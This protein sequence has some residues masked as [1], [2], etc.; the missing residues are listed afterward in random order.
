MAIKKVF[1]RKVLSIFTG[2]SLVL[3]SLSPVTLIPVLAS[4]AYA[5]ESQDIVVP[6]SDPTPEVTPDEIQPTD[7]QEATP[8]PEET[9]E[10]TP[11]L[12]AE[13]TPTDTQ[14]PT[15]EP[16]PAITDEAT[17]T[18]EPT[19]EVTETGAEPT[20]SPVT[21]DGSPPQET[22][23]PEQQGEILDG[24]STVAPTP[25][26][27]EAAVPDEPEE[28]GS[29]SA[30]ILKNIEAESLPIETLDLDAQDPLG[31][32]SLVTDK[33]DYAPTDT[34][35]IA[36]SGFIP[37]ETY[38]LI[39]SS[40]D[41]P[42]VS[43]EDT[44]TAGADGTFVYAYQLDGNYRPNYKVEAFNGDDVLIATTTF[45]D[46]ESSAATVPFSDSFGTSNTS[47]MTNWDEQ[48][49]AEILGSTSGEDTTRDGTSSNK[50]AKIGQGGWIRRT[51]N[52]IGFQSLQLKYY[53]K[54]DSDAE[55][56]DRGR[57]EYCSGATCTSFTEL[58]NHQ[59][60]NTS[61]SSLQ[62]INLPASLN[63]STFRIRFRDDSN[64]SDEYFRVDQ[65]EVS[66]STLAQPDLV[67]A[68]TNSV[69]GN[70]VIN[71]PFTWTLTV[72]NI[73]NASATFSDEDIL[74]DNLPSSGANYSPTSNIPVIT[75]GGITGSID[76]DIVNNDDL[77]C[78]DNSGGSSVV[79]PAGGSF[80][81]SITVTPTA[82]GTLINPRSGGSNK[83]QV[84]PDT[85]ETESNESN[86]SCSNS[87][88]VSY[89]V[90]TNPSLPDSCGLDV[91]LILDSS[92]SMSNGDIT[93]VKNAATTL[94][95]ALM[96]S[97]PTRIGVID[98]DT[99]VISSLSPTTNKTNVLNAVN[100]IGHTGATEYT[101]W[102]SAL[103]AA[104]AMI[105]S[106][107]L[108]VI[109][110]DG[111]PT[112]SDGPLSDLD[113]AINAANAIKT[114]GTR[115]LAI[116]INS[117]G[118]SGGLDLP[119]L[120]AITG[121]QD[122]TVPPGTITD[123]NT[124]DVVLGDISQLG[125]A[126]ADLASAL[127]GGTITVTKLVDADGNLQTTDDQSPAAGWEFN[128]GG[129]NKTTGDDGLTDSVTLDDG[130][131]SVIET[132]QEGYTLLGASCTGAV[133]NGSRD[134]NG[135]YGIAIDNSSIVSCIFVNSQVGYIVVDKVT[136]PSG[137]PQSFTFD[138][139]WGNDFN[140][141]DQDNPLDS[142]PIPA[143]TY[144]VS[145][146]VPTG[147]DP[148]SATC[149]DQSN[150]SSISLQAGETVTCTFTNTKRSSISGYKYEDADGDIQTAGDRS[151]IAD[152]TIELWQWATDTWSY[153]TGTLTDSLGFFSFQNLI[154]GSY[155][156]REVVPTGWTAVSPTGI[157]VS[158]APGDESQNNDFVNFENVTVTAC[159]Q[160]DPDGN[161]ETPEGRSDLENWTVHLIKDG[162]EVDT[163]TTGPDG[164]FT[165]TDFGPGAY[166][167]SEDVQT[168]WGNLT[169]TTND[170]G[171]VTSGSQS[172]F[173][174]VNVELGTI[175]VQKVTDP[176]GQSDLFTFSGDTGGTA[177]D[178]G[179]ITVNDLLPGQYTS[180]ENDPTPDYDLTGI[181]CDDGNSTVDIE[182]RTA[183]I[184]VEPGEEV[185]CT[186]TNT[187]RGSVTVTKFHDRNAD[188][189][190]DEEEQELSE[191]DITLGDET[192]AT[193]E[194]GLA[195]F[196]TLVPGEYALSESLPE[197]WYQS[198][199]AC[200]GEEGTDND[201]EHAVTVDP[202][203]DIFCSI[204]NYQL[205][206]LGG[207]KWRDDGNG[208]FDCEEQSE[209]C[210]DKWVGWT[211]FIDIDGDGLLD[212]EEPST[213]TDEF[214]NYSFTSLIPGTYRVCEVGQPGWQQTY[215]INE[216]LNNCH[217]VTVTS[218]QTSEDQASFGNQ[219]IIPHL[220]ITKTND[221]AGALSPGG[222]VGFTITVL[223]TESFVNGV[224]VTDL[225]AGGFTYRPGSWTASSDIRGDLTLAIT[226]EPVYASPGSWN[227]G[228]MVAG[229]TVTL[230]YVADISH[231]QQAGTYR[232]IA[233]SEGRDLLAGMVLANESSD[234]FV[235]TD[236]TVAREQQNTS[237]ANVER[238]ELAQVLS[239]T[240]Q[241]PATGASSVWLF[242]AALLIASGAITYT[243]GMKR[244]QKA[245]RKGR[246]QRSRHAYA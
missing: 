208:R 80:S 8:T 197:G 97:T 96:P 177:S 24:A 17:P 188:G 30:V 118:T 187:K 65:V 221:A 98:F 43:F 144:S 140:L 135:I 172:S 160:S 82:V 73:G 154:P 223:A 32:A 66:G 132:P 110:T 165:W 176:T 28:N 23:P 147:W 41:E 33:A 127:C 141:A 18:P 26:P 235:G 220:V 58:T 155:D 126:L 225:P 75:S 56:G 196:G 4:S 63:N 35:L 85:N 193:D 226:P 190:Q 40:E 128:I 182:T 62:T 186:F 78:D 212:A 224:V 169:S 181:V 104:N 1:L 117:S 103:N 13:P 112:E 108:V 209:T 79:I 157:Q 47:T 45:T 55:G 122:I 109:I 183:T 51:I 152:W 53:W 31:S 198:N 22:G 36:G 129:I 113:D 229:E 227:L 12:E 84:D 232:D 218:G 61:W 102:E 106:G 236:V 74:Q 2:L 116:G 170:F 86:N 217:D 59:L 171:T 215:P 121:P 7:I 130:T 46:S 72:S 243:E 231:G 175:I 174:F 92:D 16:T 185:T 178:G 138:P 230:A 34:V 81:V 211:I 195:F 194:D 76:C 20:D 54:G 27:D 48:D 245:V 38:T 213:Q 200:N 145:E 77:D 50:F 204:G 120:E 6:Q 89:N 202:G 242:L 52:A 134:G 233:W 133:N 105:G 19:E 5:Q 153:L 246:K 205:G 203:Q 49:P 70:A 184:N 111:N 148:T 3:Q 114:S 139:S 241:L 107:A 91:V 93:T 146:S 137:D 100:S 179:N 44:V 189:I 95:N 60:N 101:N 123:I 29:L 216:E 151:P 119:N 149:S 124:V 199:I 39:I 167:V 244:S 164:C 206:G 99:T 67:V 25:S 240:S 142:G 150:P 90:V 143:G 207:Y 15:E 180:T 158:P 71:I 161:L 14:T 42:P 192:Q 136:D 131:Y 57:V 94:V 68:K 69:N 64:S 37:G 11:T 214:G 156:V 239:A 163:K 201:N 168:G 238:T 166:G 191:W 87:V 115:I 83:C 162:Q 219:F 237:S 228:D 210:E 173:T 10:P 234:V 222:S 159:K 125:S 9:S 21:E 88:S